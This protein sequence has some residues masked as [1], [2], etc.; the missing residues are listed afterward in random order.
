MTGTPSEQRFNQ[1]LAW[2]F[3]RTA[4]ARITQ[5]NRPTSF[6]QGLAWGIFRTTLFIAATTVLVLFQSGLGLGVLSNW[7]FRP[8]FAQ[9]PRFQSGL[10]LG[11]LSNV[12]GRIFSEPKAR[13]KVSIRAWPGGS[14]ER[15]AAIE[16]GLI[17]CFNQ[18]LAWGFFRTCGGR[19]SRTRS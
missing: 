5:E 13:R 10:G 19:T 4:Q 8:P 15:A 14:F 1:G 18:G 2:G 11:V 6:N 17:A 9:P 12:I 3:F 16:L 7:F